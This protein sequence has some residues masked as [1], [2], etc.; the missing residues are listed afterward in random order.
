MNIECD[1]S[2]LYL[3]IIGSLSYIANNSRPDISYAVNYLAQFSHSY[4][5]IHFQAAKRVL[6]YL[7]YSRYKYLKFKKHNGELTIK[8]YCDASYAMEKDSA[9]RSGTFITINDSPIAWW[10]EKQKGVIATSSAEAEYIAIAKAVKFT[11]FII[12]ILEELFNKQIKAT[13]YCDNMPVIQ[14]LNHHSNPKMVRHLAIK[15]H[16]IKNELSQ[17]CIDIVYLD[18]KNMPA[19]ILTKALPK[20][21]FE[22]FAKNLIN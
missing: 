12:N 6:G 11:K 7:K 10:S 3:Q 4:Q 5:L 14:V 20:I 17:K 16:Y 8:T 15:H 19:D 18:T 21:T 1:K 2:L 13:V 22:K 9:S